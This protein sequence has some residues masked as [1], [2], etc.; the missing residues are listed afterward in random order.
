M[1]FAAPSNVYEG[2]DDSSSKSIDRLVE[3]LN[4]AERVIDSSLEKS[5]I[6]AATS[7]AFRRPTTT[8]D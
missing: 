3:L 1:S 2:N 7:A 6:A 5:P 8:V 4:H